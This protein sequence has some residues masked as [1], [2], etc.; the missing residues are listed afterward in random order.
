LYFSSNFVICASL[1]LITRRLLDLK[2]S[3]RRC[4]VYNRKL[5]WRDKTKDRAKAAYDNFKPLDGKFMDNVVLQVKNGPMDFQIREPVSPLFGA[6]ENTNQVMKFQIAQEYTGQQKHLCYLVP[7]WKESLDF[8]T[9]AKGRGSFASKVV[10]G[11]LFERNIGGIAAVSNLGDSEC[12]TGNPLAQANLY[13]F[14]RIAWNVDL[15]SQEIAGEWVRLTFGNDSEVVEAMMDMLLK[16]RDVYEEY[17]VPLG[18]GWMVNPNHHYGPSVDGYEYSKWGTYHYADYKGI[19]VDRS[20]A[21]GSA[22]T[23]QY[24][25]FNAKIYETIETCPEELL[26]F[27]H[28]VPYTYELKSDKSLIQHIYDTHFNGVKEV[29][30]MRESWISIKGKVDEETYDLVLSKFNIQVEDAKEWRDVINTYFYRRTG[31]NDV[32]NRKIY[33]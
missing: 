30:Y 21:T 14:G 31:I 2:F 9:Y 5:D 25:E 4:F 29:L 1:I 16:S 10:D 23:T 13:G 12:W 19:G 7:M 17:T 8:D 6:M 18:I 27:F 28:H 22:Y 26:L 32:H 15:T 20:A 33:K 3:I 24:K 11:T